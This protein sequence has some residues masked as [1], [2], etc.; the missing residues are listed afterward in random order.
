MVVLN[1]RKCKVL[2]LLVLFFLFA[3]VPLFQVKASTAYSVAYI[4]STDLTSAQSYQ[5]LLSAHDMTVDLVS[6]SAAATFNYGSYGL[7]I[8]GSET[9]TVWDSTSAV[10]AVDGANKPI[11]GLGDGGYVFFGKLSL[12]IGAGNGWHGSETQI[13]VVNT[14]HQIFNSPTSISIPTDRIITLYT[15]TSHVGIY[16]PSPVAGVTLLG[17]E[18]TDSNH[19]PL[20]SQSPPGKLYCLWGFDSSP[21]SMTQTGKDLFVNLALWLALHNPV[22]SLTFSPTGPQANQTV[23]FD[24]SGSTAPAGS[25][26]SYAWNFGDGATG[27]GATANHIYATAN[28][29]TVTLTVTDSKGL[30]GNSSTSVTISTASPTPTPSPSPTASPGPTASP[31]PTP[32]PSPTASPG[33]SAEFPTGLVIGAVVAAVAIAL[34]AV[35]IYK[36]MKRPK[37]PPAPAQLRITAE[38]ATLVADGETKSVMT[39]QLLDKKGK[40][41]AAIADTQVQISAAKGKLETPVVTIP[42]GK[43]TEKAVIVSSTETWPAPVSATAE[44]LKSITITL[45]FLEKSRYCMHCG[46][47]MPPMAKACKNCGKLPPAGVDTKVC[48]N[49]EAVIPCVAKFCSECG[50]GQVG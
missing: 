39:I 42:K 5:S 34:A 17:R 36:Y 14:A 31:T 41:I 11:L 29:Y 28:T 46:T 50:A 37:K 12:D 32:S 45:N 22:A 13:Y 48:S 24:A 16:M 23:A 1:L 6:G 3:L 30:K 9:S 40:P 2:A 38:P 19:Y 47:L 15:S 10:S 4:Y 43:D 35:I 21:A 44:G 18:S 25:I 8:V 26:V 20:I 27:T 49:C 33:P 7:I